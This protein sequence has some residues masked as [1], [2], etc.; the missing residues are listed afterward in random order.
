VTVTGVKFTDAGDTDTGNDPGNV[1][2]CSAT[3]DQGKASL[4]KL[5]DCSFSVP[6]GTYTKVIVFYSNTFQALF[7]D[8]AGVDSDPS[9]PTGLVP[10]APSGGAA[11]I[12]V[13]DQNSNQ[14]SGGIAT[15]FSQPVT[16]SKDAPPQLY[17]VFNPIH[18]MVTTIGSGSLAAPS[19]AGNPPIIP[20]VSGFS[21][22]AYYTT[23]GTIGAYDASNG[24][25]STGFILLY[26]GTSPRA[27]TQV[28]GGNLCNG[29]GDPVV[30]FDRNSLLWGEYG[31]LGLDT[32]GILSWALAGP[33]S[34]ESNA[35]ISGYRGLVEM[36]EKT[37]IGD[38]T[39]LHYQCTTSPPEPTDSINYGSGHPAMAD[40]GT[41]TVT[42][43]AN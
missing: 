18:W 37:A 14:D 43:L 23:V 17:V 15:Y 42:L 24:S 5:A 35:S 2:G 11:F 32:Q 22:A 41:F 12:S 1:S 28:D 10:T 29:N 8:S 39:T 34:G 31:R 6:E 13:H 9:S 19:M 36:T 26:S 40:D 16:V 25:T 33:Y 38:T 21:K 7:D 27:A 30:S 4:L 20:A 3:Y